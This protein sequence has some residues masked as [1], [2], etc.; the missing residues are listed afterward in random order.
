MDHRVHIDQVFAHRLLIHKLVWHFMLSW[1]FTPR[2]VKLD[3]AHIN[4]ALGAD[5]LPKSQ[6]CVHTIDSHLI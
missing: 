6:L 5:L 3:L 4:R 1:Y 2:L